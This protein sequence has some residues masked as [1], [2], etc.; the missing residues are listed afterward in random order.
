MHFGMSSG[1]SSRNRYKMGGH[2]LRL[3]NYTSCFNFSI[4]AD[5]HR[6]RILQVQLSA[7]SKAVS[8]T[9]LILAGTTLYSALHY[10]YV[11]SIT[12]IH[13]EAGFDQWK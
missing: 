4:D 5:A 2:V 1:I 7:I 9:L 12:H 8:T 13:F 6:K 10:R 3:W 11:E